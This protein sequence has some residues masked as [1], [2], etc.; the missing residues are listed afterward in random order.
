MN[1][2]KMTTISANDPI[3]T[4]LGPALRRS[5]APSVDKAKLPKWVAENVWQ[6]ADGTM[7][8]EQPWYDSCFGRGDR[9]QEEKREMYAKSYSTTRSQRLEAMVQRM[10]YDWALWAV[11]SP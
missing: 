5:V 2:A 3:E 8:F 9:S 6:N 1:L 4:R 7:F 11:K 10:G